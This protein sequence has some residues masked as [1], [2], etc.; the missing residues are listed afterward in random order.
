[1]KAKIISTLKY[2]VSLGVAIGLMYWVFK[3]I[4]WEV[5]EEKAKEVN[6]WWVV[7]SIAISLVAYYARAYRWNILLSPMGYTQLSIHR[8]TLAILVGYLAN[9]VFPRL[10][11]VTRCG[12]MKR[13]DDVDITNSFGTVITERLVDFLTLILLLT[14]A[15]LLEYDRF[16]LFVE[17][18]LNFDW[19][20]TFDYKSF[21]LILVVVGFLAIIGLI[22]LFKFSRV[23]RNLLV[24]LW[25]G[26]ISLKNISNVQGFILSTLVLWVA[27]YLMSY[28][29]VYALPETA[30]LNWKVGIMLLVTGGI[31]LAIPVQGGFGTYHTLI[32]AMLS[33]YFVSRNTGVFLAT[34]LHTSQIVATAIFGGVALA[35]SF[36]IRRS[37]HANET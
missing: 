15:L 32:S 35:I 13:T 31:A 23:F 1:M 10:G 17:Q 26:M 11:E 24:N 4:D 19:L 22:L 21:L 29:I 20:G 14:L 33:L 16:L 34:L 12:M 3:G 8:T 37:Q 25:A 36:F 2:V 18:N 7:F 5:F 28:T 6:Y 27:Y 9:L 30:D